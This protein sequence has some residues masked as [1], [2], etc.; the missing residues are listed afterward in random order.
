M[1][2]AVQQL[3]ELGW[4][5]ESLPIILKQHFGL[6]SF[7]QQD[8]WMVASLACLQWLELGRPGPLTAAEQHH[9]LHMYK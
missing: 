5:W 6:C 3:W 7:L 4:E 9:K 2:K 1:T 8:G